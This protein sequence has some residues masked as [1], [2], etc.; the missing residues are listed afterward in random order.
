MKKVVFIGYGA[1]AQAVI[2]KLPASI[3][4]HAVVVLPS[5]IA[6]TEKQ[7]PAGTRVYKDISEIEEKPDLVVEM[8]GPAGLKAHG[9]NVLERGWPLAV[10]SVGALTDDDLAESLRSTAEKNQTKI[11]LLAGAIAGVDGISAAKT[12][13]LDQVLYQGRKHPKSWKGSYAE[14]VVNLDELTEATVFFKGSARDAA[15]LFP[16]NAN[17]AATIGLA[18]IGMDNTKVE[19]IADPEMQRNKHTIYAKGGFGEMR[20]EMQ[21]VALANNPKT[22]TLA[23]LSVVRACQQLDEA[24]VI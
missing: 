6:D 11:H 22:S 23:A 9:F 19:L 20:I 18:G 7:V 24:F 15:R 3:Q 21:G 1:M 12:L 16:A 14:E 8:A 2:E 10:I 13:G 17:V 5:A 4:L